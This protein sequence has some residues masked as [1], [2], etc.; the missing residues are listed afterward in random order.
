[1]EKHWNKKP[2][3]FVSAFPGDFGLGFAW[4]VV[5]DRTIK[6]DFYGSKCHLY[7]VECIRCKRLV[8]AFRGVENMVQLLLLGLQALQKRREV[9]RGTEKV[10]GLRLG[11]QLN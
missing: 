6:C 9:A 8:V 4:T 5:R 3:I 7:V 11:L 2:Q 1:M 10:S